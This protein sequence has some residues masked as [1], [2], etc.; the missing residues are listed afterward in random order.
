MT[1]KRATQAAELYRKMQIR[2][3]PTKKSNKVSHEQQFLNFVQCAVYELL[4]ADSMSPN[5]QMIEKMHSV[6]RLSKF[7]RGEAPTD[8]M[9]RFPE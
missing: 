7:L 6:E 8:V 1:T 2:L 3:C 5:T 9:Q 4:I